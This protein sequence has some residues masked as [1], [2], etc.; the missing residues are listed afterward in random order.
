MLITLLF[1][2]NV[3][4]KPERLIPGLGLVPDRDARVVN[5]LGQGDDL[6]VHC[7][8]KDEDFG[9]QT[10]KYGKYHEYKVDEKTENIVC[11]FEFNKK[12]HTFEIYNAK[13]YKDQCGEKCWWMI[14]ENGPCMFDMVSKSHI[15]CVGF[16]G[17]KN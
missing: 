14:K 2:L 4:P 11:G 9:K 5:A 13:K 10:L 16:N 12:V 15:Y 6:Y 3:N 8:T 1:S 7:R 17:D